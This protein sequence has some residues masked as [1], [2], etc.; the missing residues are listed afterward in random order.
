MRGNTGDR[1]RGSAELSAVALRTLLVLL[2]AAWLWSWRGTS[3]APSPACPD[4]LAAPARDGAGAAL[5]LA[6]GLGPGGDTLTAAARAS[7]TVGLS[8]ALWWGAAVLAV[9]AAICAALAPRRPR[10]ADPTDHTTGPDPVPDT[11]RSHR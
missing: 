1:R 2:C 4:T 11:A 5:A 9:A 7:F 10:T 6:G 8:H 3:L